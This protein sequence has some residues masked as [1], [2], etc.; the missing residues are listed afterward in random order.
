V[1]VDPG[2]VC[3][4]M[5]AVEEEFGRML[6]LT[7]DGDVAEAVSRLIPATGDACA[8]YV[9]GLGR[10]AGS[11]AAESLDAAITDFETVVAE[12][13]DFAPAW[14]AMARAF[15]AMGEGGDIEWYA[16]GRVAAERA[17]ELEPDRPEPWLALA[18]LEGAAG[19]RERA[20]GALEQAA[21]RGPPRADVLQALGVGYR[22]DQ[23]FDDAE[24]TLQRA[25]RLRPGD[26]T[27]H[28]QLGFL[29]YLQG[30]RDAAINQFRLACEC[31]PDNF[32]NYSNI[33]AMYL[34]LGMS[35]DARA[36]FERSLAIR[37]SYEAYSNLGYLAFAD[38]NYG[39]AV[40][41]YEKALDLDDGDYATR[42]NLGLA[43][44]HIDRSEDSRE[45]L[46]KAVEMGEREL[47]LHPNDKIVLIDLAGYLAILGE[48]DRSLERLHAAIEQ[49]IEDPV[50]MALVAEVYEDLGD[51]ALATDWLVRA[52]DN[53]LEPGWIDNSPTLRKV[54]DFRQ[55]AAQYEGT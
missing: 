33:G 17:M 8:A 40:E 18:E 30:R 1:V 54:E 37:P 45:A 31:M 7:V 20:V 26:G 2:G 5:R 43:F 38:S 41:R 21:E 51:R 48:R 32:L 29:Y 53:G 50:Q 44:H 11:P 3:G 47:Q 24:R 36:M 28:S 12:D 10:I 9:Y 13:P 4:S 19:H 15:A 55:L 14:V 23:R 25:I 34:A 6:D 16:R 39:E 42:G 35:D 49:E 46:T 52:L 22:D 27:L